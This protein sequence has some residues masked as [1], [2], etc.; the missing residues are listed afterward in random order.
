MGSE[1]G[2]RGASTIKALPLG[3]VGQRR[4]RRPAG[5][6]PTIHLEGGYMVLGD[7][8]VQ[9]FEQAVE[10]I[11]VVIEPDAVSIG[12]NPKFEPES[13]RSAVV[14]PDPLDPRNTRPRQKLPFPAKHEGRDAFIA[15]AY[16]APIQE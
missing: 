9:S 15:D 10:M 8:P 11:D 16:G 5:L 1:F 3:D 7:I 12:M 14:E 6:P 4:D 2:R 13:H